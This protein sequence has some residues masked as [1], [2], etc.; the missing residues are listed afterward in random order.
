MASQGVLEFVLDG[1]VHVTCSIAYALMFLDSLSTSPILPLQHQHAEWRQRSKHAHQMI[2]PQSCASAN[3]VF[4]TSA[5]MGQVHGIG[6]R[7][8][9]LR[10]WRIGLFVE[11]VRD[12]HLRRNS[13]RE[14]SMANF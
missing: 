5:D 3:S 1:V 13:R 4:S 11:G 8:S 7:P 10:H 9:A 14:A 2:R 12:T 6:R